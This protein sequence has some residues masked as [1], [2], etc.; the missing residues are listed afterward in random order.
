MK[1]STILHLRIPFF[2]FLLPVFLFACAVANEVNW[3][4]F[5][6]TFLILHFLVYPASNG[7]NSYF[8]K[9]EKSIGGLKNP[10]PVTT[11]LYWTALLF[12]LI[13]M[14]IGLLV[15]LEFVVMIFI[16]GLVSKAYSH[17]NIRLKKYPIVGWLAAGLFQGYFTYLL[18]YTALVEISVFETSSWQIH[19][20]GILSSALL[21]GSYP[22][23]Q[24][25]QHEEDEMRGDLTISRLLGVT[26]TF[27]FTAIMF[28]LAMVGFVCFFVK[29][30][31]LNLGITFLVFLAPVL[32]Y[33]VAWYL[34]VRKNETEANFKS[35]MTLNFIS[36]CLL[37]AFF[38]YWWFY[39]RCEV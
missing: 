33:F 23:T 22:M 15:S 27:H 28:L 34:R 17:P 24:V 9:D 35:T 20:P 8:D 12:D 10:P 25:Y 37:A 2:F 18:C 39:S 29:F 31:T 7:F 38:L 5:W 32:V 1:K 4:N 30:Y 21:L 16:Y 3:L 13:G 19:F 6:L 26:G 14:T 11:Q 36:A